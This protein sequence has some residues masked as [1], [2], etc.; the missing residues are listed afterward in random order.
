MSIE[1]L[2]VQKANIYVDRIKQM[3]C[4]YCAKLPVTVY[5]FGSRAKGNMRPTS[6]VDVAFE[7]K[8]KLP[9]FWLSKLRDRLEES[10][11][12]YKVD[13]VDLSK[14]SARFKEHALNGAIIWKN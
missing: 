14:T 12:P 6:D 3:V 10:T 4:D 9:E 1:G 2:I 5:F 8:S 7:P 13:L 11:I